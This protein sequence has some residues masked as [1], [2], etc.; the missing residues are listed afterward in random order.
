MGWMIP[1]PIDPLLGFARWRETLTAVS[2][3]VRLGSR[4]CSD[5]IAR[6]GFSHEHRGRNHGCRPSATEA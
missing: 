4:G 3:P 6:V 1:I 2:G 5:G